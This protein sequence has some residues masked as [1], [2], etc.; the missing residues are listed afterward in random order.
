LAPQRL[1]SPGARHRNE[2]SMQT[3][4]PGKRAVSY[5]FAMFL[6]SLWLAL[7]VAAGVAAVC[8][9]PAMLA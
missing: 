5:G 6:A 1:A 4:Y 2:S 9:L 7:W 3:Q 8:Y